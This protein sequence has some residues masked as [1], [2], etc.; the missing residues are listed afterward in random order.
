LEFT[1]LIAVAFI[2][3]MLSVLFKK[4]KPEISMAIALITGVA[5]FTV[6][7]Y[8]IN[9]VINCINDLTKKINISHMYF[10]TIIKIVGISYLME[11]AIQICKDSGEGAIA[12]K[13]EFGGKVIILTLSFP[14]LLSILNTIVNIIP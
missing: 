5:I 14:I 6:S 3:T 9:Y 10:S 8:K 7:I 11:F 13:L 2:G 12:T 1:K 4:E